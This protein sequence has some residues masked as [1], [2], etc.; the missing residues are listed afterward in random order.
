MQTLNSGLLKNAILLKFFLAKVFSCH[1]VGFIYFECLCKSQNKLIIC[2][3]F[4]FYSQSFG[5]KHFSFTYL[6][7]CKYR[8]NIRKKPNLKEMTATFLF[9][10]PK[11]KNEFQ[12]VELISTRKNWSIEHN[13][14]VYLLF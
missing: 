7:G 4:D 11:L 5:F 2:Y 8:K 10:N 6:S 9:R 14:P 1:C 12:S 13:N 3:C